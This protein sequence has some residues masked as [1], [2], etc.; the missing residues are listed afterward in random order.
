M[1]D[2]RTGL[3]SEIATEV[4]GA[5][6]YSLPPCPTL[7]FGNLPRGKKGEHSHTIHNPNIEI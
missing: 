1:F 5:E 4:K 6:F 2:S 7:V 3:L